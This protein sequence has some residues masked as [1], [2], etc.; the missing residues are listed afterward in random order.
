MRLTKRGIA[1]FEVLGRNEDRELIRALARRLA[2]GGPE[3]AQARSAVQRAVRGSGE[4][5]GSLL[6]ALLRAP[7]E[8][9]D[10]EFERCRDEG[11][12]ADL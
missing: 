3:A 4:G 6:A 8:L 7:P 5:A 11:R 9:A 2:E 10:I 1:R 12:K